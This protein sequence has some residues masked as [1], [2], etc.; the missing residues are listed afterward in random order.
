[1]WLINPKHLCSR[2]L[3]GEHYEIHKFKHSFE[4]KHNMSKRIQLG[5]IKPSMMQKRH[6]E[7]AVEMTLR[8]MNH[9]SPYTQPDTSYI[10]EQEKSLKDLIAM[11]LQE[12]SHRCLECAK[13]IKGE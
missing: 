10:T 9:Q 11:N 6:D 7:L 12:L 8:G 13:I 2:H 4:K 5:Q 3:L 1:M